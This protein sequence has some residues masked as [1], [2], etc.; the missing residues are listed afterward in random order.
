MSCKYCNKGQVRPGWICDECGEKMSEPDGICRCMVY[1]KTHTIEYGNIPGACNQK[2]GFAMFC[3]LP[4]GHS[5][6]HI[7]CNTYAHCIDFWE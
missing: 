7:A 2:H 1:G 3:T 6:K 5:G 4:A